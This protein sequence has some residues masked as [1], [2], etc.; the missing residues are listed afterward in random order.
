MKIP[1]FAAANQSG[2]GRFKSSQIR[3][4]TAAVIDRRLPLGDVPWAG[5]PRTLCLMS[6]AKAE[7]VQTA[8]HR[9]RYTGGRRGCWVDKVGD[10]RR[11]LFRCDESSV[12]LASGERG[13]FGLG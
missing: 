4:S 12:G 5:C 6:G 3:A 7:R 13:A 10:G 11:D 9:Q 8:V 2:S 1:S